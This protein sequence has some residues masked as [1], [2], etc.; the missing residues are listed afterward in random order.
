MD[1]EGDYDAFADAVSLGAPTHAPGVEEILQLLSKPNTNAIVN[2]VGLPLA[3]RPTFFAQ[4]LPQL[5]SLR[6]RT[7]RPHWIV[8]DEAHHLLP[9]EWEPAGLALPEKLRSIMQIT[10]HPD[11]LAPKLLKDVDLLVAVGETPI[12][13]LQEFGRVAATD[14]PQATQL[15]LEHGE[16][17]VWDRARNNAPFVLRIAPSHT[18]RKRHTR[19]YAAGELPP[20]RSF[21]FRGPRKTLNLRAHNLIMFLQIAEGVDDDTWVYHLKRHDYSQWIGEYIKDPD[22]SEEVRHIENDA[23]LSP[24]ESRRHVREQV[25]QL[26]TLP[27]G[28]EASSSMDSLP[29]PH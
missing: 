27:A 19:K 23:S 20:D 17:L 18:E 2:L 22:L 5:M 14:L 7:G 29:T 25:E 3:D 4:L 12:E 1:P 9:A 28:P 8:I 11:L 6:A 26:Y 13:M 24:Q 10:V 15:K 21:Y 16:A